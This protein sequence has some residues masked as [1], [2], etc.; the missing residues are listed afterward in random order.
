MREPSLP[1][2]IVFALLPTV[3]LL[4]ALEVGL[5]WTGAGQRCRGYEADI[6][7]ACDPILY[8]KINPGQV[9]DGKPLSRAGFRGPDFG[10]RKAGT[11]RVLALGDSCTYGVLSPDQQNGLRILNEPYPQRLRRV[12][13]ERLGPGHIEV[14]NAGV[15]GYNTYQGLMLLRSKLRDLHPDVITVRFG[16]N[17]LAMSK[18]QA[19]GNAF[20]ESD[21]RLVRFVED[22]LLRTEIYPFARRLGTS[23][24][25]R[26]AGN[27]APGGVAPARTWS[28]N[29]PV[30]RFARNLRRIVE[31]GRANGAEVWL[32]TEPDPLATA[33]D[34]ARY[35]AAAEGSSAKLTLSLNQ[36]PSFERLAAI[37][38]E[39]NQAVRQ[40]AAETGAPLIDM[41]AIY[42]TRDAADLFTP[43]DVVHPNESGH[44]LEAE[45]LANQL[46]QRGLLSKD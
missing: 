30:E 46:E 8:F 20:V 33:A 37:L 41:A 7:W 11:T 27:A 13:D 3:L 22:L 2:K 42:R 15:P 1:K 25:A 40:V 45:V 34:L 29:V 21:N 31:V 10:D 17:D 5:R 19:I 18:E 43:G 44:Q 28:P 36:I 26:L 6:L 38:A 14:F 35:R 39:Y 24:R 12:V 23:L 4:V 32:I 9:L 16:W